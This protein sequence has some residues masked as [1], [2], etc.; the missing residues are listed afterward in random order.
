VDNL[1]IRLR[2][3]IL[4]LE[5][6]WWRKKENKTDDQE[7]VI[8]GPRFSEDGRDEDHHHHVKWTQ[9]FVISAT[10]KHVECI[11]RMFYKTLEYD[12]C[13]HIQKHVSLLWEQDYSLLHLQN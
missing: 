2:I 8:K 11:W 7:S 3:C 10:A 4:D 6:K 12:S 5:M 9:Q 1:G 13:S